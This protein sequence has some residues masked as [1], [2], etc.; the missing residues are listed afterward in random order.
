MT[1]ILPSFIRGLLL[2]STLGF[3]V[4]T[5][6]ALAKDT[7]AYAGGS[8][9]LTSIDICSEL[10]ALGATSCDDE[11]TGLKVFGGYK[12]NRNLAVEG[13]YVDFGE[14]SASAGTSTVRVSSD[15]LFAAA[16]GI[17]PVSGQ[18]SVFGKVGL[19]MWDLTGTGTGIGTISDDGTDV[20]IGLGLNF[21]ITQQFAVRAEWESYDDE[22]TMLS[23]GVQ[24]NF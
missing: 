6:P 24:Y 2:A 16:V 7:G 18:F 21:D 8:I 23:A 5:T 11:D 10:N 13:G 4:I 17:L 20:F 12:F 1:R 14:I 22:M 19:F 9:G 15:A 3:A